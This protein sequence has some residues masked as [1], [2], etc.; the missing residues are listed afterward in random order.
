M[1]TSLPSL[2]RLMVDEATQ[3]IDKGSELT[4][5]RLTTEAYFGML[6]QF[7]LLEERMSEA[8]LLSQNAAEQI[9]LMVHPVYERH[10]DA[11]RE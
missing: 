11:R 6:T 10:L 1:K 9:R 2:D 7:V 4:T 8:G 3:L 5:Y